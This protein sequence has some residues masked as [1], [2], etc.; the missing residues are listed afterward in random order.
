MTYT[1]GWL[2]E[3]DFNQA[4]S[5]VKVSGR[6]TIGYFLK[7]QTFDDNTTFSGTTTEVLAAIL[8]YA[9]LSNY[10]IQDLT[11][12]KDFEFKPTDTL[13]SRTE[14]YRTEF[15]VD[16]GGV[17]TDGDGYTV[18]SR[19]ASVHG[20]NRRQSIVDLIKYTAEKSRKVDTL[21]ASDIGAE[22]K[23]TST[24]LV[25]KHN[26]NVAAHPY[27]IGKIAEKLPAPDKASVGQYL[28]VLDVDD[29][30]KVLSVEAIESPVPAYSEDD[31]GKVLTCTSSGLLW[32]SVEAASSD[33]PQAEEA[34]F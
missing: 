32:T 13:F 4:V 22:S 7:D 25:S 18:Y 27:L 14:G 34:S 24:D 3:T 30:G 1:P 28:R 17:S 33:L 29:E 11:T 23:G 2:D 16:S 10:I 5:T 21:N 9:G 26:E 12:T 6:N 15:S 20:Y 8:D 19:S 31:F